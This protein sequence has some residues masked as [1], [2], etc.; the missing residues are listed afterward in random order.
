MTKPHAVGAFCELRIG[1][2]EIYG[3]HI[4]EI[5]GASWL[6]VKLAHSGQILRVFSGQV[7]VI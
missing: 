6:R 5:I 3:A 1:R 2:N 7:K 4:V